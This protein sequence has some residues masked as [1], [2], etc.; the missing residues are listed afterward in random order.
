MSGSQ[1]DVRET[2]VE[3]NEIRQTLMGVCVHLR[4][5]GSRCLKP[6]NPT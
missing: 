5:Y 3:S 4:V 6:L 1:L 2:D